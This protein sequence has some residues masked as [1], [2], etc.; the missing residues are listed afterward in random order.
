MRAER[1]K[2]IVV[3][4]MLGTDRDGR[5]KPFRPS[6]LLCSQPDR[7][8]VSRFEL[9]FQTEHEEK[10][11][12][13]KKD[14]E[15]VSS[16]TAVQLHPWQPTD[17]WSFVEIYPELLNFAQRYA[18]NT[19]REEYFVHAATGSSVMKTCLFLL[20]A[21][22]YIPAKL[23]T[24][25]GPGLYPPSHVNAKRG[26]FRIEDLDDATYS[27]LVEGLRTEREAQRAR[28][29]GSVMW[30]PNF[31]GLL[32]QILDISSTSG[33]PLLLTGPSGSGKTFLAKEI[34]R[35]KKER[36]L[37]TGEFVHV[38]C[39]TLH[40]ELA[41]SAL[42][43]HEK[44]AYTGAE[45]GRGGLIWKAR[46]G[47][48]FLDEITE[49]EPRHQ[50]KLLTCVETG[51]FFPLG[52]DKTTKV[53]FELISATNASNMEDKITSGEFREDLYYRISVHQFEVP[54]LEQ[55]R[56]DIE[57][58]LDYVLRMRPHSTY[59]RTRI[60]IDGNARVA[61][62]RFAKEAPWPGNLRQL[63]NAITRM[64]DRAKSGRIT[65]EEV[66]KSI[67]ELSRKGKPGA[68]AVGEKLLGLV[69]DDTLKNLDNLDCVRLAHVLSVCRHSPS[70]AAASRKLF[71][72]SLCPNDGKNHTQWLSRYLRK[73]GVEFDK[74]RNFDLPQ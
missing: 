60:R 18:F 22:R 73:Y 74:I 23:V 41:H 49:L 26:H 33:S 43:G 28:L 12:L 29:S 70:L 66:N 64:A 21:R 59:D 46:Q 7:F 48:L 42:F 37:V 69:P 45:D 47:I 39:D 68:D 53:E 10:A 67:E 20:I 34:Y 19:D 13:V 61:F 38:N 50:S 32:D 27:P 71:D 9:L 36:H 2:S 15:E 52:S 56:E 8:F 1:T 3:I 35:I 62:L 55:R 57:P 11:M 24:F 30:G 4:G 5:E 25:L 16:E 51:E 54:G 44:G 31:R 17:P 6:I 65:L 72:K 14:I 40:G 63:Q 58:F